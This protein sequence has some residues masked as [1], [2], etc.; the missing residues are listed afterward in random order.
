MVAELEGKCKDW[1]LKYEQSQKT[2]AEKT[3][4]YQHLNKQFQNQVS[5]P[6]EYSW[7]GPAHKMKFMGVA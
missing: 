5:F 6:A 1:S 3:N 4:E 7:L 2:L